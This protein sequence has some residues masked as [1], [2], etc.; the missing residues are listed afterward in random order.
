MAKLFVSNKD[1][2]ARLFK[3]NFLEMFTH[4]H[5]SVPVILY[6]PVI[7]Y[8]LYRASEAPDIGLGKG[9]ALFLFG[10]LV[11]SF[12]EYTLHRYVFHY[13]PSSVWGKRLHFLLHGVHHDYPND[14]KRLVMPPVVSIPLA[15]LFY[16]VFLMILG[17]VYIGPFFAG[18]ILGYVLYDTIHY[19][20][21]HAP[22]K[23]RVSMWLK[24]HHVL[25]HYR[26]NAKGFG[27]SSPLWDI[28]FGTMQR[29]DEKA[30]A[31]S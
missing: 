14:S 27:V 11:W 24:H 9:A 19:A 4:V 25:H 6:A 22:M 16:G 31:E 8:F 26:D 18:F 20:T 5:W 21:H 23:G 15:L 13:E 30:T 3:S 1:E 2:S 7:A 29:E 12:T 17:A 10:L 28:V